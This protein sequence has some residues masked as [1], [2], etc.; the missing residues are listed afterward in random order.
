VALA[1]S[2]SSRCAFR[3]DE[4]RELDEAIGPLV[5]PQAYLRLLAL[6]VISEARRNLRRVPFRDG[7]APQ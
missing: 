1:R 6:R 2:R 7:L 3:Q 4:Y 5:Q